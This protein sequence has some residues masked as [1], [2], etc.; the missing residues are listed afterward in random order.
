M[1]AAL[2]AIA[3]R[4]HDLIATAGQQ[5]LV[6][7]VVSEDRA[8]ID[9]L[10]RE[11]GVEAPERVSPL[12]SHALACPALPTCGQAL[13]EA[14]RVV[15]D[16]LTA[17]EAALADAGIADEAITVRMTGCPN[18]CARPYLAEIGIVG[19]SAD[20]YQIHLGGNPSSTRLARPW[21]DR[22]PAGEIA[23]RLA[24]LFAAFRD[25]RTAGESFGDWSFRTGV[26]DATLA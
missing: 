2:R 8:A 14:E 10:L 12:R 23:T 20:R 4:G 3:A 24:P 19:Q 6:A 17:I 11:H 1:K 15:P 9:A 25:E 21:R 26:A 22:V 13:A 7:D 5:V 16:I 18:G